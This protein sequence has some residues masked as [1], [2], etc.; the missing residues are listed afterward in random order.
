MERKFQG[1]L[2][3]PNS[4]KGWD[5]HVK[6]CGIERLMTWQFKHYLHKRKWYEYASKQ[7]SLYHSDKKAYHGFRKENFG[8]K[9]KFFV[10]FPWKN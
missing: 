1:M 2:N 8:R 7:P 6:L 9:R 3:T 10:L 5:D 4:Y